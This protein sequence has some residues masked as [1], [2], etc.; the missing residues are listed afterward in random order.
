MGEVSDFR[1]EPR[2]DIV[3][4]YGFCTEHSSKSR[5]IGYQTEC[6][7][8]L[9]GGR[10]T[11]DIICIEGNGYRPSHHGNGYR[12]GGVMYS[13]NTTEVHAV[14]YESDTTGKSPER[15][16]GEDKDR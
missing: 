4:V 12:I 3:R 6:S 9:R 8:T 10:D 1:S 7:P 11:C 5:G 16:Q 2:S 13:L 14:A 15:Q